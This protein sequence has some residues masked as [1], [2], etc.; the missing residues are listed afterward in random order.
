[1]N[2]FW[3]GDS[4]IKAQ[5]FK[6]TVDTKLKQKVKK[7]DTSENKVLDD[8]SKESKLKTTDTKVETGSKKENKSKKGSQN[9][10]LAKK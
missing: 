10:K 2:L 3:M 5:L 6:K 1:M 9:N 4:F 8:E 7:E